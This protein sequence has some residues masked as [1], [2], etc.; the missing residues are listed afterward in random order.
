MKPKKASSN[1]ESQLKAEE[2]RAFAQMI[3]AYGFYG[4]S[5]SLNRLGINIHTLT[6][7]SP[8][9]PARSAYVLTSFGSGY[10]N[11]AA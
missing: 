11:Y 4:R 5:H 2:E 7:P 10:A 1:R 8:H 9:R 3:P 6:H